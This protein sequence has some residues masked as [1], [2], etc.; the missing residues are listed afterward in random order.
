MDEFTEQNEVCERC[1]TPLQLDFSGEMSCQLCSWMSGNGY[2]WNS[3][4]EQWELS[5]EIESENDNG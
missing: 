5:D 4:I 3:E 2:I 1:K